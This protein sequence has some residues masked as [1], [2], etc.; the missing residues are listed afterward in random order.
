VHVWSDTPIQDM[1]RLIRYF[2]SPMNVYNLLVGKVASG[3]TVLRPEDGAAR[4]CAYAV[5]ACV[6]Q[7]DEYYAAAETVGLATKPLLQYYGAQCLAKAVILLNEPGVGTE[8]VKYH[9][10]GTRPGGARGDQRDQLLE[11]SSNPGLWVVEAE[12]GITN[13]GVLPHLCQ[14]AGDAVPPRGEVIRFK[15]LLRITPDLWDLYRR[16]FTES[17]HAFYLAGEPEVTKDGRFEVYFTSRVTHQ[18]IIA[19]FPEFD[20]S[21]EQVEKHSSPGFRSSGVVSELPSF[22]RTEK[23][24]IAGNYFLR[25]HPSGLWRSPSVL[26]AGLYILSML[27]RYKPAFWMRVIEGEVSGGAALVEAFCTLARR[28]Y[29]NDMLELIWGE[30][31]RFATPGYLV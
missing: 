5:S 13:D 7:A 11:Y 6:R 12:F 20:G 28:R 18:Q 22:F 4:Q 2:R 9:G 17:H 14:V 1:W 26:Y 8:D 21:Y 3:R 31:V 27:V 24:T 23:G 10:L 16:H 30:D 29:P 19:V 25:P 15:E